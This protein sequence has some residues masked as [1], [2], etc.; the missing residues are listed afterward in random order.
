MNPIK[1]INGME[2]APG[3]ERHANELIQI[4]G[5]E[6]RLSVKKT[7]A[8]AHLAIRTMKPGEKKTFTSKPLRIFLEVEAEATD[9]LLTPGALDVALKPEKSLT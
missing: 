1:R 4:Y 2:I 8:E 9:E 5:E 6:F 7:L 3:D